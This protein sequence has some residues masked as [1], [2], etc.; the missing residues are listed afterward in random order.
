MLNTVYEE[1][2]L[3]TKLK[4]LQNKKIKIKLS[5]NMRESQMISESQIMVKYG[6]LMESI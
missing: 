6:G 1:F 3:K 5:K 2:D 4:D